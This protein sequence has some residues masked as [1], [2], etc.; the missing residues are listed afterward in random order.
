MFVNLREQAQCESTLDRGRHPST[1]V[2]RGEAHS[3]GPE[4]G[5]RTQAKLRNNSKNSGECSAQLAINLIHGKWKT[6]ILSRLQHGPA[7]LGQ[8]RRMFPQ[9]SK[10]MLAQNLREMEQD[11]LVIRKDLSDRV[12]H[13]EYSLSESTGFAILRLISMLR[14]WS[15]EHLPLKTRERSSLELGHLMGSE[16]MSRAPLSRGDKQNIPKAG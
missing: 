6:R 14:D 1:K 11:G 15:N 10:K 5:R 3:E 4:A 8:L 12:L 2:Y 16:S 13:V 9:A 7:R